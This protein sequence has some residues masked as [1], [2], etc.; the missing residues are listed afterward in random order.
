MLPLAIAT[1]LVSAAGLIG[2]V[3][4]GAPT[5]LWFVAA[6]LVGASSVDAGTLARA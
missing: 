3:E 6:L 1:A 4:L 2:A 5:W